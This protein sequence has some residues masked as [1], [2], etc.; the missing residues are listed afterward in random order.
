VVQQN[1]GAT[2]E[3][4]STAEELAS[5]AEQLKNTIAFFKVAE[6]GSEARLLPGKITGREQG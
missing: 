2:E 3:I 1:A 4:A 5:Q 6:A